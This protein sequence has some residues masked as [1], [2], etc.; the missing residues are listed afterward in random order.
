MSNSIPVGEKIRLARIARRVTVRE[1]GEAIGVSYAYITLLEQGKYQVRLD[2]YEKI[3]AVLRYDFTSPE[4]QA[5]FSFFL[6]GEKSIPLK[7]AT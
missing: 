2:Q 3:Q 7:D 4:A 5:A 1:L 6:N